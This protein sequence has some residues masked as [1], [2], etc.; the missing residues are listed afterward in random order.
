MEDRIWTWVHYLA[1]KIARGELFETLDGLG[2]IRARVLG[3]L[4]L[5]ARGVQPNGVRRLERAAPNLVES[6]ERTV[7]THDAR[8]CCA[9]LRGT[10]ALYREL[11]ASASDALARRADAERESI[12]FLDAVEEGL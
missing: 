5:A 10:I 12:R 2:F 11:R 3:P 7:A 6:F 8:S 1:G 9:A 4:A